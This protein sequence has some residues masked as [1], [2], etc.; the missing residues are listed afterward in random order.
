MGNQ[1]AVELPDGFTP[2]RC[3]QGFT[4][5][6]TQSTILL[7]DTNT[8]VSH[9]LVTDGHEL[10]LQLDANLTINGSVQFTFTNVL[11]PNHCDEAEYSL[12]GQSCSFDAWGAKSCEARPMVRRVSYKPPLPTDAVFNDGVPQGCDVCSACK[13]HPAGHWEC[14]HDGLRFLSP[15]PGNGVCMA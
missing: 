5:C 6:A 3:G 12:R 13:A 7:V 14:E 1:I 8:T 4:A 9:R 2:H 15:N 11:L 10:S